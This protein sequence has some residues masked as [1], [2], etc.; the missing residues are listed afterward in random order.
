MAARKRQL[1]WWER[2]LEGFAQTRVGG[3]VAVH[4]GNR[5]DRHLLKWTNGRVG[6]FIGQSVG[7]LFVT[8][9]R[10]GEPRET[11]LLYTPDGDRF[12]LVASNAGSTKHPA[13]YHN[14]RANPEVEFLPRGGPRAAYRAR[15]LDGDERDAAW[16]LVN[17][18]YTGY[19]TY[20]ARTGGRRIPVIALEPAQGRP[21]NGASSPRDGSQALR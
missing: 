6:M 17:D 1:A 19:D 16:A 5:V 9:A 13:W 11:P 20:Q 3:W 8:G 21:H 12:L 15:E 2:P 7:L 14:V 18:M 10:S 4:I